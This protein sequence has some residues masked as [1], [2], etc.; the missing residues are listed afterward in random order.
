MITNKLKS[1]LE[2]YDEELIFGPKSPDWKNRKQYKPGKF[3]VKFIDIKRPEKGYI[4]YKVTR[5]DDT[6]VY[7]Y[8]NSDIPEKTTY[9]I[10]KGR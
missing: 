2:N 5:V 6:G 3:W 4:K 8:E 7:G 10:N 9:I 1:L